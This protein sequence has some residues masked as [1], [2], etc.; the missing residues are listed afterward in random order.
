M[1]KFV[2]KYVLV[3]FLEDIQEGGEFSSSGWPL[4]ITIASNFTIKCGVSELV[5]K[6]CS[7]IKER[8]PIK[9]TAGND[10]F[11]GTQKQTRVTVLNMNKELKSLHHDLVTLLKS[12]GAVFDE[13][14]YIEVGFRAHV[15]VQRDVR[16]QE[17]DAVIIDNLSLV[18]M[19]PENDPSQRKVLR[20]IKFLD[21]NSAT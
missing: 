15:T 12:V 11:F 13:P 18:D 8:R 1:Q 21:T 7:V 4:H 14:A 9:V 6:L 16:L 19:F 5:E 3:T 10:E 20:T 2:Q 17:G